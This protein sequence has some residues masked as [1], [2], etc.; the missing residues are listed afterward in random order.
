VFARIGYVFF[1]LLWVV[2]SII[3]L[4]YGH[5]IFDIFNRFLECPSDMTKDS[6]LQISA[7]Y[8]TSFTL[9]IFHLFLFLVCLCPSALTSAIHEGA[10][11]VKFLFVI[12]IYI[13]TLFIPNSFFKGYGYF[14]MVAGFLYLLYQMILLIDLAYAWN[15]KWIGAYDKSEQAESSAT[16]CWAIIII[17]STVIF[18]VGALIVCILLFYYFNSTGWHIAETTLTLAFA[19]AYTVITVTP[20]VEGG[21]IF[22]C[23][24]FFLFSSYMCATIILSDPY[25]TAS[26]ALTLQV[27]MGL[28]FMFLV[29]FYVS[30]TTRD[31]SQPAASEPKVQQV[32]AKAGS[33][34]MEQGEGGAGSEAAP[35]TVGPV[36]RSG[37]PNGDASEEP[38]EELPEVTL[39][40][41]LFH[42]L[43]TFASVY[44]AMVLTNWG[45]PNVKNPKDND[46]SFGYE[47]LACGMKLAAQWAGTLLFV[48]TLI[49]PRVCPNRDFS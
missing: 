4:Y 33:P 12:G 8:R 49:A 32:A 6:C 30:G 22:T 40:T 2:L 39:A 19:L 25:S 31:A 11:G 15:K 43:M 5:Y 13:C 10:W 28:A 36:V 38:A 34:V 44:Y 17:T 45:V 7:V 9:A 46:K 1:A 35:A 27:F 42:L 37:N 47:W 41:A 18:D 29:L 26:E 14:A 48:W 21:S 3:F 23:S 16:T 20:I 24:L